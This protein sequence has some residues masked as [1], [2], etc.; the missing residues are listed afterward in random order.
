MA[1]LLRCINIFLYLV[2]MCGAKDVGMI[3]IYMKT[4]SL[5]ARLLVG[6]P[7]GLLDFVLRALRVL[8]PCDPRDGGMIG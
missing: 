3:Y 6:G 4:R 1:I 2:F 8:R 5:W 7:S